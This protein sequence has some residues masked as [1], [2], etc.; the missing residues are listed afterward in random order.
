MIRFRN[1]LSCCGQSLL[2]SSAV[3]VCL[4]TVPAF[5]FEALSEG[6]MGEVTGQE[7]ILISLD[8][9][10]NSEATDDPATTGGALIGGAYGC[11]EPD[12][13]SSLGNNNCRL[14]VQ[15]ENR[16]TEWLV[17]K[18]GHASLVATRLSLDAS[19][20]GEAASSAPGYVSFFNSEKFLDEGNNCLLGTGNCNTDYIGDM[21]AVRAHYP[22][23]G[24]AYNSTTFA[25]NGYNDVRFGL[26][27]EGLAVEPGSGGWQTNVNGSF[28][29][30]RIADNNGHQA[31]IAFGGDFYLYGF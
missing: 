16:E 24:G 25:S 18:N 15:L 9:Y 21:P 4:I 7:G 23:T 13:A 5:A 6:E 2:N 12:G 30:L 31:G 8:Y 3:A 26:Y 11:A 22:Q 17:F 1:V 10:Y 28:M 20:L 14:A 19:F 27:F 29:G